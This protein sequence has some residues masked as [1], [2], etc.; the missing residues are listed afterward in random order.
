VSFKVGKMEGW[1]F[2]DWKADAGAV[3]KPAEN[4]LEEIVDLARCS[5]VADDE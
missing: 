3:L 5:E 1:S 2:K 4:D